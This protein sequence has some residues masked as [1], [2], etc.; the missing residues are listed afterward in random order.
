MGAF[1]GN[2]SFTFLGLTTEATNV[3]RAT[4]SLLITLV[5][6]LVAMSGLIGVAFYIHWITN[7]VYA[8]PKPAKGAAPA[9]KK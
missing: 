1:S 7:K 6:V 4:P 3:V 5:L 2:N 9:G 8:K